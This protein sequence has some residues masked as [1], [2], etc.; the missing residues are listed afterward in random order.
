[1]KKVIMSY[2]AV[3]TLLL[4][5]CGYV[6]HS[7]CREHYGFTELSHF[8]HP[9]LSASCLI[10]GNLIFPSTSYSCCYTARLSN[11][12]L[13]EQ[14]TNDPIPILCSITSEKLSFFFFFFFSFFRVASA[15]YWS[16]LARGW[17]GVT[18][19]GLSH[20]HSNTG[21]EPHLQPTPPLT[22]MPDP[23]PTKQGQ[24]LNPNARGS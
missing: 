5:P 21:S 18:A 13:N 24:G 7:T 6:C 4:A 8:P 15:T 9:K 20:S 14:N 11:C 12:L 17:I 16:S 23:K 22:A 10:F 19:P 3:S 2:F 1:M